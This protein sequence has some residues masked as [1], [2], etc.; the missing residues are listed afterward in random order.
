MS[1]S[2]PQLQGYLRSD[3]RKGIR[4]CVVVAYLVDC[5]LAAHGTSGPRLGAEGASYRKGCIDL[6][7][8]DSHSQKCLG[9]RHWLFVSPVC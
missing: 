7:F 8:W 9:S 4:N 6:L 3:G 1:S 5:V 2:L